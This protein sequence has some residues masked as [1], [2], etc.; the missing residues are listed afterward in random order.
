MDKSRTEIIIGRDGIKK[1]ENATVA[2]FGLGGV[3]GYSAEALARAGVGRLILAD[4]DTVAPSNM[5]RQILSLQSAMG[6]YK[7]DAARERIKD[8]NSSA[9]IITIKTRLLPENMAE[10]IPWD[11]SSY[12]AIDAIDEIESKV[13]LICELKKKG[14]PFVSSMGTGSRLSPS[15]VTVSDI[16][17]TDYC[18]LARTLRKKLKAAGITGGVRCIY[19]KENLNRLG[20]EE[21]KNGM[22]KKVQGSI[23]YMPGIFGLTAA[24]I[25]I[26]DILNS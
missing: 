20:T 24:G 12:Y 2:L 6:K 11:Y 17:K 26:N 13:S 10:A 14:I 23:S 19:S 9:E 7:T 5:N 8:I 3:G 16:S 1:L 4:Y 21:L 15:G 25:I 18:P 22:T